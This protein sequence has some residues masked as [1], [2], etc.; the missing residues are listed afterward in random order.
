MKKIKLTKDKYTIVDDDDYE[1]L[2]NFSWYW[3]DS[4]K[5]NGYARAYNKGFGNKNI[6][7]HR[8]ILL[9]GKKEQVDHVNHNT[10]DNRKKNLRIVTRS[11]NNMNKSKTGN[12][13]GY[14]GVSFYNHDR[15][16]KTKI[17]KKSSAKPYVARIKINGKKISLGYFFTPIEAAQAYNEAAIKYFGE[18]A[19]LNKI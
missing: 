16:Y 3:S 10:L 6:Y 1:K 9:A 15:Y 2:C 14:K 17:K 13:F 4:K 7:L 19:Y 12:K 18:Y 5:G 8:F 11:Q